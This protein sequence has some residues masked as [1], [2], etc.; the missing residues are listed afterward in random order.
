MKVSLLKIQI[1]MARNGITQSELARRCNT[2]RQNISRVITKGRCTP[3][4][5]G[6]IASGLGVD[7]SEIMVEEG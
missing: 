2:S 4:T 7:V 5:A 3:I 1:I 6:R